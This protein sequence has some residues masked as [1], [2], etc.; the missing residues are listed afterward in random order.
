MCHRSVRPR[1][2][3]GAFGPLVFGVCGLWFFLR[4]VFVPFIAP[5]GEGEFRQG[6]GEW[7]SRLSNESPAVRPAVAMVSMS[8]SVSSMRDAGGRPHG[9]PHPRA[10]RGG[11]RHQ[12]LVAARF[13][14]PRHR[15][16]ANVGSTVTSARVC[17]WLSPRDFRNR[18]CALSHPHG[19]Y[20]GGCTGRL[21]SPVA[22][23]L[24]LSSRISDSRRLL[25]VPNTEMSH[26][27]LLK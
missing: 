24:K 19:R 20:T 6:G 26:V 22:S 3:H 9:P 21:K 11:T 1:L 8:F 18:R 4:C 13:F 16:A 2:A 14:V 23:A 10:P 5:V 25:A 7:S 12:C 27:V 15:V 17:L